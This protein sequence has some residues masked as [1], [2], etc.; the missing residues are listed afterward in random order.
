[1]SNAYAAPAQPAIP[2]GSYINPAFYTQ[3]QQA[4]VQD[5]Q[6]QQQNMAQWAQW[7]QLAAAMS[8]NQGQPPPPTQPQPSAAPAYQPQ[9]QQNA[10]GSTPTL[11]DILRTL[12]GGQ[13]QN[14]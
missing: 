13:Q 5:Q 12:G 10:Q 7:F 6:Q 9:P 4:P 8:Q 1:M 3:Q 11:Q 2:A 14:R